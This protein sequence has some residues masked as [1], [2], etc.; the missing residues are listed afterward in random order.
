[1]TATP[2]APAPNPIPTTATTPKPNGPPRQ[3]T[4]GLLGLLHAMSERG[5]DDGGLGAM[6]GKSARTV[7]GW[8]LG[9]SSPVARDLPRIAAALGVSVEALFVAPASVASDG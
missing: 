6:L 4:G 8:R 1:M 3:C 7:Q 5:L 2:T 9:D